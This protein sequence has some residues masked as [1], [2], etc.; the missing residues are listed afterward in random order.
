VAVADLSSATTYL[1]PI[2]TST[3]DLQYPTSG[4]L[5][6]NWIHTATNGLTNGEI[7]TLGGSQLGFGVDVQYVLP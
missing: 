2:Y 7:L 3:I 5:P 1:F 6:N 4:L